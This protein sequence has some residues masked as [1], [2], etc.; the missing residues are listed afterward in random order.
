MMKHDDAKDLKNPLRDAKGPSIMKARTIMQMIKAGRFPTRELIMNIPYQYEFFVDSIT[1]AGYNSEEID[2]YAA[3]EPELEVPENSDASV[4]EYGLEDD[5]SAEE[6]SEEEKAPDKPEEPKK[7]KP[8]KKEAQPKAP[9][10]RKESLDCHG[11]AVMA[12]G[13]YPGVMAEGEIPNQLLAERL[14]GKIENLGMVVAELKAVFEKGKLFPSLK[15]TQQCYE[16]YC[17][18]F[19]TTPVQ[20]ADYFDERLG[21]LHVVNQSM[22]DNQVKALCCTIPLIQGLKHVSFENNNINDQ[23]AA[24]ILMACYMAP[25]CTIITFKGNFLRATF[26]NTFYVLR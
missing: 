25:D 11:F 5:S 8:K 18:E 26:S 9:K 20:L 24:A 19:R 21:K 12:L 22:P 2:A 1:T 17:S 6:E 7:E 4:Y 16:Q 10:V 15:Q 23:M 14:G 13:A 3:E